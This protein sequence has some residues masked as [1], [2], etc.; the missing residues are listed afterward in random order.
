MIG[1][2][3]TAQQLPA[4]FCFPRLRLTKRSDDGLLR[5]AHSVGQLAELFAGRRDLEAPKRPRHDAAAWSEEKPQRY[6]RA[7]YVFDVSLSGE[8]T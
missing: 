5:R 7:H 4:D 2:D 6:A 1:A 8:L 3:R